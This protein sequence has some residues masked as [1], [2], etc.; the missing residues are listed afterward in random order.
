MLVISATADEARLDGEIRQLLAID[1]R[2][3]LFDLGHDFGADA[4]AGE[5]EE[6]LGHCQVSL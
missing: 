1:Q 6:F 3:Q 5:E 2:D 4:V